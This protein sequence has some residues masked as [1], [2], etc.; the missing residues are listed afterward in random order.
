MNFAGKLIELDYIMSSEVT[1][2]QKY[3]HSIYSI[4]VGISQKKKKRT[5]YLR[6]N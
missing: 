4:I 1:Q 5:E 3:M 2:T 6:Y